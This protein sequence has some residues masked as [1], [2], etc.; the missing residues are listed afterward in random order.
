MCIF[1]PQY[2]LVFTAPTAT[3]L[4]HVGDDCHTVTFTD[5]QGNRIG[6][7]TLEQKTAALWLETLERAAGQ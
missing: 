3:I 1:S 4:V 7:G 2:G 6:G 5:Q